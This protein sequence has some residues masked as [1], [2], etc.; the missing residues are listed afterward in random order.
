M[1]KSRSMFG[2]DYNHFWRQ[3]SSASRGAGCLRKSSTEGPSWFGSIMANPS[4][5]RP[6]AFPEWGDVCWWKMISNSLVPCV[7]FFWSRCRI[8]FQKALDKNTSRLRRN[9]FKKTRG[10][11]RRL[12][13]RLCKRCQSFSHFHQAHWLI[14]LSSCILVSHLPLGIS[15][16]VG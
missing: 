10:H 1:D 9:S 11:S 3:I 7:S 13:L 8:W 14:T 4:F 16:G 12:H 15:T 2:G 5:S 6:N